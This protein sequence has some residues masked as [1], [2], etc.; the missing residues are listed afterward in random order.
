M[1]SLHRS[2]MLLTLRLHVT[3]FLKQIHYLLCRAHKNTHTSVHLSWDSPGLANSPTSEVKTI[4]QLL[5]YLFIKKHTICSTT[6]FHWYFLWLLFFYFPESLNTFLCCIQF[7][8]MLIQQHSHNNQ[9][10]GENPLGTSQ[11][12]Q[13]FGWKR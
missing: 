2:P 8:S 10:E 9:E 6:I 7:L 5:V 12:F 13:S 1:K 4:H 11:M 3:R